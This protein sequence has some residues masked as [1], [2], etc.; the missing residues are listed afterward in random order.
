MMTLNN[1]N[2]NANEALSFYSTFD[3]ID[4]R[5]LRAFNQYNVLANMAE[6]GFNGLGMD[7]LNSLSPTDRMSLAFLAEYIKRKGIEETRREIF[8]KAA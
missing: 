1:A 7:Y 3:E 4:D 8:L 2:D 6:Q 5:K